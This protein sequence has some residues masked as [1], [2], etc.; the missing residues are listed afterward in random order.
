[1]RNAPLPALNNIPVRVLAFRHGPHE[2]LGWI[3]EALEAN[4]IAYDYA[5]SDAAPDQ[6]HLH[7]AAAL[8]FLGGL[9]SANDDLPFIHR[10]VDYIR[11]A[12]AHGQPVLG[13]CLGAQLIA[14]ALGARVYKNKI[15]EIGWAPI[16]FTNAAHR[17]PLFADLSRSETVFQWHGDTFDLPDRTELLASSGQCHNQAFRLGNRVYGLQFHLEVTAEMIAKW[18]AEDAACGDASEVKDPIDP[19]AHAEESGELA[20]LVFDRWCG[21]VKEHAACGAPG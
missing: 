4:G 16:T 8:I 21:L 15:P 2:H 10:E 20:R 3:C 13:I 12:I 7:E 14:K 1:M 17:D 19:T 6:V 18:C 5:D 11:A 9:M